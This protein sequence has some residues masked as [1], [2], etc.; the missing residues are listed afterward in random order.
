ME[1]YTE[2]FN[3]I[4]NIKSKK[5][6]VDD[7]SLEYPDINISDT[8]YKK[9]VDYFLS[10]GILKEISEKRKRFF[11]SASFLTENNVTIE[12]IYSKEK[13]GIVT[14]TALRKEKF[15]NIDEYLKDDAI[16]EMSLSELLK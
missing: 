13:L 9:L 15:I 4:S 1:K 11:I 12:E 3:S 16:Q 2:Y 14:G 7:L 8:F 6:I 10:N 5:D